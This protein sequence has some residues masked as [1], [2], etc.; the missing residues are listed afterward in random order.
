MNL[1]QHHIIDAWLFPSIEA[2]IPSILTFNPQLQVPMRT[3][4]GQT[5]HGTSRKVW[6]AGWFVDLKSIPSLLGEECH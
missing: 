1:E 5:C 3:R 4:T 6:R 2:F